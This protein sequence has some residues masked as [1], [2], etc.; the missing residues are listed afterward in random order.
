MKTVVIFG[1]SG[2]VGKHIIRRIAKNG[3][4]IIIPHQRPIN[5]AKLRLLGTTGQIFP[6]RF[7]TIN[8]P[9]I[10]NIIKKTDVIINLKT[11]WDEKKITYK[12]GIFDFNIKLVNIFKDFS[13]NKQ[14][15][16]FSGVGVDQ[17]TNSKRSD[18]ILKSENYIQHNIVNSFIIRPGVIIGEESQFLKTLIS[19]FKISFFVPLF[20]NG[21]SKFQ[22]VFIDDVSLAVNNIIEKSFLGNQIFEFVG[23]ETFTYKKFYNLI[24]TSSRLKRIFIKILV[25]IIEKTPLSPINREQLKLFEK[26]NIASNIYKKFSDLDINPQDL[27]GIIKKIVKKSL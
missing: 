27:R 13:I 19:L 11:Q 10:I 12:S 9:L 5:E 18:A 23:N 25:S 6:L 20:G 16:Y 15:I 17:D 24:L 2:F 21:E 4:K 3:Y 1:G 26:D 8:E 22:P 7:R 14:L